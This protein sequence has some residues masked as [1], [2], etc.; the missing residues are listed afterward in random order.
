MAFLQDLDQRFPIVKPTDGTPSDYFMRLIRD[1]GASQLSVEEQLAILQQTVVGKA[2]K[3]VTLTAG[4]GLSGGGD[5]SANSTFDLENTAVTPGSYTNTNLTVDAQGRIT[6]AAN[7]SG[8]SGGTGLP[9]TVLTTGFYYPPAG[10]GFTSGINPINVNQI[11]LRLFIRPITITAIAMEVTTLVAAS[12]IQLGIYAADPTTLLPTTLIAGSASISSATTGIK[13]FTL[14]APY[15]VTG[16]IWLARQAS[17]NIQMRAITA[18]GT[19][20]DGTYGSSS[21]SVAAGNA[22]RTYTPGTFGLPAT[23]AG[24]TAANTINGMVAAISA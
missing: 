14:S 21:I 4:V 17:H 11:V 13:T 2:D 8:G 16:P 15:V 9:P 12:N 24:L 3:S 20:L 19:E 18:L 7:G 1:R 5:L 10:C 23:V 22:C 6:A